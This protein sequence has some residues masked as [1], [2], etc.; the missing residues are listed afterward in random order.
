MKEVQM[1]S[2]S[3]TKSTNTKEQSVFAS[4]D[5]YGLNYSAGALHCNSSSTKKA[6]PRTKGEYQNNL[7]QM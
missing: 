3:K 2:C 4:F 5:K 1:C 7:F 6:F